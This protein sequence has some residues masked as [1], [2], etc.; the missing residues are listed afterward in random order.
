M[1]RQASS[2]KVVY[3]ALLGNA[4]IAATKFGAAAWTG[5]SAML[6]EAV[7]SLVDTSNELLLLY[8]MH[9]AKRPPDLAH[10]FGHGRELYFWSFIVAL[11]VFGV[12]AGVS[13]YEGISHIRNPV[14]MESPLVNYA[15]LALSFVFESGSWWVAF[16]EFRAAKGRRSYLEAVGVAKDPTTF[17]VLFEDSAALVGLLIAF[18][19][20]ACAHAFD[21]PMLDGAASIGIALVLG[22]AGIVLARRTKELLIGEGAYPELQRSILDIA[23]A[24][25]GVASANGVITTQLGPNQ[26][27][28]MLSAEFEDRLTTPEIEECVRQLEASVRAAYPEITGLFVKPQTEAA[29]KSRRAAMEAASLD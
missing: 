12:G 24:Q 5:S 19:G 22:M 13:L 1:A 4:L 11:M 16:R 29:W 9:R 26:V 7:H 8:G 6:S 15:V 14:E 28:A 21:M 2:G 20:I 27:I 17:T 18:I 25:P 23:A 10:P 3:A